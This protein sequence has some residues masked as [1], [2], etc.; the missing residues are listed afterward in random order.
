MSRLAHT[1]V[2]AAP[3]RQSCGSSQVMTSSKR[4]SLV[5]AR[6]RKRVQCADALASPPSLGGRVIACESVSAAASGFTSTGISAA[7]TALRRTNIPPSM[8]SPRCPLSSGA[9]LP[10]SGGTRACSAWRASCTS[11]ASS[12][13][14][15]TEVCNGYTVSLMPDNEH[16]AG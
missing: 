11:R 14:W 9:G 15:I 4:P 7:R 6:P 1:Q 5:S 12:E 2:I 3:A 8:A 13:A 16:T 10:R